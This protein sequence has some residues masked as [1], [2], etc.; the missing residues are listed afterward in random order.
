MATVVN[1]PTTSEGGNAVSFLMGLLILAVLLVLF[2]YMVLPAMRGMGTGI[3]TGSD[4]MNLSVPEQV[5]VNVN[6]QPQ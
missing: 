1:T 2:F 5:D 3:D 6:Q 4:G